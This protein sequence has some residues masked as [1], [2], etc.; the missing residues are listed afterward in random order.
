MKVLIT[1]GTGF[2]G[3][4]IAESLLARPNTT[5]IISGRNPPRDRALLDAG[6]IFIAADLSKPQDLESILKGT[7]AIIHCA[8]LAGTW[9]PYIDY[10]QA[11]VVATQKLLSIAQKAGVKRFINISSPSIY[12]DFLDQINLSEE[13]LPKK[14]S[15]A[16]AETKYLAENVVAASHSDSFLTVSLRPRSVIGR[17]DRNVIP[18]LIRL[19]QT[20]SLFQVGRGENIV[21]I[22]SIQNL[23]DAVLLCLE[24]PAKSMGRTYNITNGEPIR[25]W[26]FVDMVLETAAMPRTRKK[27]PYGFVMALAMANEWRAKYAWLFA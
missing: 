9:G 5:V 26:N 24:A 17:G 6:A 11:N 1:G 20:G 27:L 13:S 23:I 3:G 15:N 18:R 25:F 19:Q 4:R 8:G 10:F 21:D 7:D 22:T 12:F 14:F 16:Y 2:I